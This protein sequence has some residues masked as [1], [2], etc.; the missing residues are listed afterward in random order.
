MGYT[1]KKKYNI[2]SE[3]TMNLKKLDHGIT[4]LN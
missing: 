3:N 4:N 2:P 1:G